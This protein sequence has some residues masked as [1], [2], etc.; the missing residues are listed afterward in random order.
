MT[1]FAVLAIVK[2]TLVCGAAF[3][4]SRICRRTRASIRHLLFVLAFTALIAIP[5]AGPVLPTVTVAVP[6]TAMAPGSETPDFNSTVLT[7]PNAQASQSSLPFVSRHVASIRSLTIPQIVAA[8]WFLGVLLF[9]IPVIAGLWQVRRLRHSALPWIDGQAL[10]EALAPSLGV[11]RSIDALV[12]A[13]LTGPVTCGVL[14]PAIILPASAQQWDETALR[15]AVKHELEHVARWDF[16]TQCLS[17]MVCAAVLVP[18][19]GLGRVATI[20]TGSRAGL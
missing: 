5:I 6:V 8:G 19:V 3:F 1:S 18:S 12:H 16:L 4:L 15:C 13:G 9:L 14:K 20:A 17:R 7:R 11:Y 10:V 2:A